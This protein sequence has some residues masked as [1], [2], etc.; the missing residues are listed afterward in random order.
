MLRKI[1]RKFSIENFTKE[2][3]TGSPEL[4]KKIYKA[5]SK[6]DFD[7]NLSKLNSFLRETK[8]N[9]FKDKLNLDIIDFQMQDILYGYIADFTIPTVFET[10]EN[11]Y[12]LNMTQSIIFFEFFI[13]RTKFLSEISFERK[14][15]VL[16]ILSQ[17][18]VVLKKRSTLDFF[19]MVEKIYAE[20]TADLK[21]SLA[22]KSTNLGQIMRLIE[23]KN[24]SFLNINL[25][26]FDAELIK[27]IDLIE[28]DYGTELD[29]LKL[30]KEINLS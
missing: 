13:T 30:V 12:S 18:S 16:E 24:T 23:L 8:P 7:D 6:E 28:Q 3:Y 19:T 27:Q 5:K 11:A 1:L 25:D 20:L 10:M 14:I 29:F 26:F 15:E 9:C 17:H 2:S 21:E 4:L 22:E